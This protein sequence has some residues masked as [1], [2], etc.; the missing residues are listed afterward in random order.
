[1]FTFFFAPVLCFCCLEHLKPSYE[2]MNESTAVAVS[3][4]VR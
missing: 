2:T 3:S 1:L 4:S